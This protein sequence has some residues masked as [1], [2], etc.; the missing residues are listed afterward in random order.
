MTLKLTPYITLE[1]RTKEA[2]QFYKQAIGAKVV[3]ILTY[4][5][6]PEME[7][8]F[9]D[10]MKHMVANAKL[11]IGESELMFSDD[12]FGSTIA[13]SKKVTIAITTNDV[14][15]SRAIFEALRQDGQVNSPFQEEAFSPGFGDITDKFGV[16]FQVYTEFQA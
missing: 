5:E 13:N 4:G 12:P 1:G 16:N 3:S 9:Q 15:K 2:I 10:E 11:Q 6:I 14:E 8:T 7:N